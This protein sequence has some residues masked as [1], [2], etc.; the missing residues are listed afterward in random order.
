MYNR[1]TLKFVALKNLMR[2]EVCGF[3]LNWSVFNFAKKMAKFTTF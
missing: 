2:F 3:L 1:S